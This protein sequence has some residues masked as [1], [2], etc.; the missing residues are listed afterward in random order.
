MLI[1]SLSVPG[2]HLQC[3]PNDYQIDDTKWVKKEFIAVIIQIFTFT[4]HQ[5][6]DTDGVDFFTNIQS[7]YDLE[8]F[9][10]VY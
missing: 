10:Y 3:N 9:G 2:T 1:T 5:Q 7:L 6:S 4:Y 8:W